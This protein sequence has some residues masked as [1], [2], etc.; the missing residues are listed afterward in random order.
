MTFVDANYLL[1]LFSWDVPELAR[2]A[3]RNLD[4]CDYASVTV[5]AAVI[6]ECCF[7]LTNP[8]TY[9]FTHAEASKGL[10]Q[11]LQKQCFSVNKDTVQALEMFGRYKKLDFVD[12]LLAVKAKHSTKSVL[13]FDAELQK[14]LR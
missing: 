5:L 6:E 10:L 14:V 11:V 1:R 8:R 12:C 7:V 4:A 3:E 2:H 9:G 13:T